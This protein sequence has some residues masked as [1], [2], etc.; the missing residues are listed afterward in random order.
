M[1]TLVA[2]MSA[3]SPA[4]RHRTPLPTKSTAIAPTGTRD[5]AEMRA[6]KRP[7]GPGSIPSRAA[8]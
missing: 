6:R 7:I 5:R 3:S 8:A 2:V 1:T 4:A